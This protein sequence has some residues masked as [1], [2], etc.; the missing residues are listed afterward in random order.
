MKQNFITHIKRS[1]IIKKFF[2]KQIF[3]T[4]KKYRRR[5]KNKK[6]MWSLKYIRDLPTDL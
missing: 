1:S 6:K 3:I 4:K 5:P 2:I